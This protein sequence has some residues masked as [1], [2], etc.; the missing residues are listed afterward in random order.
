MAAGTGPERQRNHLDELPHTLP[1]AQ[2]RSPGTRKKEKERSVCHTKI[3]GR[4][5]HDLRRA[6]GILLASKRTTQAGERKR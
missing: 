5:G 6:P 3:A 1:R 2:W 4:P